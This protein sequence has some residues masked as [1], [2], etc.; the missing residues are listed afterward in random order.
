[1]EAEW[2]LNDKATLEREL[3]HTSAERDRLLSK[4]NADID[5]RKT[6]SDVETMLQMLRARQDKEQEESQALRVSNKV[7]ES[8]QLALQRRFKEQ[9]SKLTN[10]ERASTTARQNLAQAQQRA[11]DWEKKAKD[12]EGQME[13]GN[14]KLMQIEEAKGQVEVECGSLRAEIEEQDASHKVC[15]HPKLYFTYLT[16]F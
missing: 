7:L 16:P 6:K 8:E 12:F 5:L 15:S 4:Q 10:V 1:M 11:S 14:L 2:T 3:K 13:N 9:E